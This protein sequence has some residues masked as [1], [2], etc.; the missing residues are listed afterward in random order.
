MFST[1][2]CLATS[3]DVNV[4]QM[5]KK[6][7]FGKPCYIPIHRIGIAKEALEQIA[8]NPSAV[9]IYGPKDAFQR[10]ATLIPVEAPNKGSAHV[11][12]GYDQQGGWHVDGGLS[13]EWAKQHGMMSQPGPL[14]TV[15]RPTP[16][17][18]ENKGSAHVS[19]GYDQQGGW[20]VD[21][22]AS[23]EWAKKQEWAKQHGIYMAP[24]YHSW[25]PLKQTVSWAKEQENK[26]SAHVSGGY[27]QQGGWHV[28][29]GLT[30]S[31]AKQQ[32]NKGSAHVSGGYDQQGGWHVE[33]GA[34]FEWAKKQQQENKSHGSVSVSG[35]YSQ[36]KGAYGSISV[37]IKF[38][39]EGEEKMLYI[40]EVHTAEG[41][42]YLPTYTQ[43]KFDN[44]EKQLLSGEAVLA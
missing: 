15:Y 27:D 38:A 30:L 18:Q 6:T 19:G 29:G 24:D 23:F 37:S 40:T 17:Y 42:I 5:A 14:T 1:L 32:E 44:L 9:T 43:G 2:T 11:S 21:G 33:G 20:H 8:L 10:I 26:G 41:I 16:T 36:S 34:S 4:M 39:K 22:G 25:D 28:E 35:G 12:G 7:A 13:F 31:W 3:N